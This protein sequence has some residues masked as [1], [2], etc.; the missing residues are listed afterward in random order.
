MSA[1][2]QTPARPA[3]DRVRRT[4]REVF[5]RD[6]LRPGQAEASTSLLEGHDVLLV[7][8]TGAGKS[9]T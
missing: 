1:P 2:R 4:A 3:L 6:E 8:P 5:G 7:A 9:L